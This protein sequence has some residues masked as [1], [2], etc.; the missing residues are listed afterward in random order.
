MEESKEAR[1][2]KAIYTK[3]PNFE[4]PPDITPA[5]SICPKYK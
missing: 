1:I 2:L 4:D 3:F 5:L